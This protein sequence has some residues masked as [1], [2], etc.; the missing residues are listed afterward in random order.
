MSFLDKIK[1]E[2]NSIIKYCITFYPN[3]S[4]GYFIRK[5]YWKSKLSSIGIDPRLCFGI[6]FGYP[7]LVNISPSIIELIFSLCKMPA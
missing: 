3:S 7:N 2:I 5:L 1:N 6:H 4:F